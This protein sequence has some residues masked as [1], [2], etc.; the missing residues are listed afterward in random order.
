MKNM[1]CALAF[2]LVF[3][4]GA[5]AHAA[6]GYVKELYFEQL[7]APAQTINVGV[8]YW[9]EL[10]R[11][12][13][14][15][16]VDNLNIFRSGDRIRLHLLPNTNGFAYIIQLK[17]SSGRQSV[18][19]PPSGKTVSNKILAGKSCILP[20]SGYLVFDKN[21]GD[22]TIRLAI[23]KH[24]IDA[25][26]LLSD[27]RKAPVA[28]APPAC[29]F[30]SIPD[31]YAVSSRGKEL[32]KDITAATN[33]QQSAS[34]DESFSKDLYYEEHLAVSR[35]ARKPTGAHRIVMH[36]KPHPTHPHP[37]VSRAATLIV[38]QDPSGELL[39]DIVLSHR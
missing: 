15:Y 38:Q 18:L 33:D 34:K 37:A 12:G 10:K 7:N 23:A 30:K 25:A 24:P 19:F 29:D 1:S 9:I 21:P 35:T 17:G 22:E 13:R 39:A 11:N 4:V 27:Q 28:L 20:S 6:D 26:A 2:W 31:G 8:K 5:G 36:H 32:A 14:V 3:V 16:T